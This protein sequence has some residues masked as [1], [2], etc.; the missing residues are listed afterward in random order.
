MPF[1]LLA[2]LFRPFGLLAILLMP[3]DL[4]VPEDFL[5]ILLSNHLTDLMMVI[6]E[7]CCV[8]FFVRYLC[9]Y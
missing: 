2:I 4:L 7:T 5:I 9:F 6:T 8:H 3:F 1:G